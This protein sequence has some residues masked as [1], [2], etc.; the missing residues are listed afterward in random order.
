MA[1]SVFS[2]PTVF[3]FYS[4]DYQVPGTTILGPPFQIYTESTAIRRANFVNTFIFGTISLPGYA[5]AGATTVSVD[6]TP[7]ISLRRQPRGAGGRPGRCGSCRR[8]CPPTMRAA[9]SSTPSR[10]SRPRDPTNR[11]QTAIYLIATSPRS[12]TYQRKEHA[13][14][15]PAESSCAGAAA[16]RSPP[17][18]SPRHVTRF[19]LVDAFAQHHHRGWRR[20]PPTTGRWCASS[21]PAAT[22]PGTRSSAST[23]TRSYAATRGVHRAR[24]GAASCPSSRP[25]TAGLRPAPEPARPAR[26][27]GAAEAGG[28]RA[29][30]ARCW[31]PITRAEYLARPDLRPP[32]LFSHSDQVC[33][34]ADGHRARPRSPPVGAGAAGDR[35]LDMNGASPF[36]MIVSLAGRHVVRDGGGGARLRDHAA[37]AR[38]PGGFSGSANAQIRYHAHARPAA[39]GPRRHLRARGGRHR[40]QGARDGRAAH[41]RP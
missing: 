8:A 24:P 30:W 3:N 38:R 16:R 36:P 13:M 5:P 7:W 25:R 29:T 41:A 31:R 12:T 6:L 23:T 14:T 17:P 34:V 10:P 19:G 28:G 21:W 2:P 27:C 35:T 15:H 22:T 1:Q 20:W 37:A 9:A 26:R 39:D 33:A 40:E 11:A 18:P 32:S 4:P